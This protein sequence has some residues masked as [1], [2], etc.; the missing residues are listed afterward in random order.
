MW[1]NEPTIPEEI[2]TPESGRTR[3]SSGP[4]ASHLAHG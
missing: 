3:M 2:Q 4:S 1:H